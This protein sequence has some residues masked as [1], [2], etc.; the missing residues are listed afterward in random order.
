MKREY[1]Y[2]PTKVERKLL[3]ALLRPELV[4][5]QIAT[6]C[7]EAGISRT[8]YYRIMKKTEF[9]ELVNQMTRDLIGDKIHGVLQTSYLAA[10]DPARGFQ[11]RKMLLQMYALYVD[12][13]EVND[14]REKEDEQISD[15]EL[16]RRI[17]KLEKELHPDES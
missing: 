11:D 8:R 12:K 16:Q 4:G 6:I 17:E 5:K 7:R 13:L 15:Q 1:S 3:E 10:L 2:K 9:V 14:S